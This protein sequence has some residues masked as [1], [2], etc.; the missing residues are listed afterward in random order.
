MGTLISTSVNA[1]SHFQL[2][3]AGAKALRCSARG[4]NNNAPM[5]VRDPA[6]MSG[7]IE[8]TAIRIRR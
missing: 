3:N 8:P 5:K 2:R 1:S 7:S 6:T 4:S